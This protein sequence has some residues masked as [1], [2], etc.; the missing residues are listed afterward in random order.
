MAAGR[1]SDFTKA[2]ADEICTR[3][4]NGKSLRKIC[5]DGRKVCCR[6]GLFEACRMRG[7]SPSIVVALPTR[8]LGDVERQG[9]MVLAR[10]SHG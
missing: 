2:K 5:D 10:F 8:N 3:L 1:P 7:C 6:R 9:L 4:I